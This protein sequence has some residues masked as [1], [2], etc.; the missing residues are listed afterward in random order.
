MRVAPTD[1]GLIFRRLVLLVITVA[2]AIRIADALHVVRETHLDTT[3]V[4]GDSI[5]WS[6][7]LEHI[8]DAQV[9][10]LEFL[11]GRVDWRCLAHNRTASL[12]VGGRTGAASV[13]NPDPAVG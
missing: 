7:L 8:P 11:E 13:P 6:R 12:D 10:V 4:V 1:D 5:S 2:R 3:V 9:H